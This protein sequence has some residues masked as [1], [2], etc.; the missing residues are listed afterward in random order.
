[1]Q[2]QQEGAHDRPAKGRVVFLRTRPLGQPLAQGG[3]DGGGMQGKMLGA[4]EEVQPHRVGDG[5]VVPVAIGMQQGGALAP[6]FAGGVGDHDQRV[7]AVAG[8][9]AAGAQQAV[10][11]PGQRIVLCVIGKRKPVFWKP[12]VLVTALGSAR[13]A[14]GKVA[15]GLAR[16]ADVGDQSVKHDAL[17]LVLIEA[18]PDVLLK[19]TARL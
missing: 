1:V 16:T 17:A 3:G 4:G 7:K 10:V 2:R 8:L 11:F 18:G 9:A 6:V 12:E 14:K 13:L 5:R 15:E 19:I